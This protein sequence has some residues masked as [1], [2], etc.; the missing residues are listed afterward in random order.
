MPCCRH[1]QADRCF[2]TADLIAEQDALDAVSPLAAEDWERATPSPRWAVRDQIGHLAFF[3]MTAALAIDNPEGFVTH[4]ESFVAAAFARHI[5]DDHAGRGPGDV[6]LLSLLDHWRRQR[7]SRRRSR[8]LCRRRPHRVVRAIDGREVVPHR[9]LMEA[10]AH[11]QDI[12]DTV[13]VEREPTDRLR[14]SPSSATSL[15]AGRTSTG[16]STCPQ[17]TCRSP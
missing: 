17:V 13:G 11:G 4:R 10:W 5:A 12:C 8:N 7:P 15:E 3:D 14:T 9:P 6:G 2:R 16:D 1:G